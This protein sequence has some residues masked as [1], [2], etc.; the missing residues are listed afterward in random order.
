MAR[1]ISIDIAAD[2]GKAVKGTKDLSKAL[3]DVG[4]SLDDLTKDAA[5]AGD[6]VGDSLTDG[7]KDAE[8]SLDR[9]E[10]TFK[11]TFDAARKESK[12][13]GDDVGDNVKRGTDRASEAA[14]GFKDEARQNFAE[15]ASS[16]D[17]SMDSIAEMAQSTLG[18]LATAIPGAGIALAGLGAAAGAFYTMWSQNAEK[19]KETISDMY[20]DLLASGNKYLSAEFINQKISE[21]V[22]NDELV[23]RLTAA[24]RTIGVDV[25]TAIRAYSGDTE[26]MTQVTQ[27]ATE[28]QRQMG[29]AAG[30]TLV[31]VNLLTG[32]VDRQSDSLTSANARAQLARDA[33]LTSGEAAAEWAQAQAD[34]TTIIGDANTAINDNAKTWAGN[35]EQIRTQNLAVLNDLGLKLGEV[36]QAAVNAN[37]TGAELSRTQ[38]EQFDAFMTAAT[39]AGLAEDAALELAEQYGL[40]PPRVTSVFETP[41]LDG[42]LQK[43]R[44]YARMIGDIPAVKTVTFEGRVLGNAMVIGINPATGAPIYGAARAYGGP[45]IQG[46]TYTVGERQPEQFRAP[47]SGRIMPTPP[48]GAAPV[49]V[50]I[51]VTGSGAP[52]V[53]AQ[54]TAQ[55][56]TDALRRHRIV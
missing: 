40:I 36:N 55:R 33:M 8:K 24:A 45:V 22:A 35:E 38:R 56:L 10:R 20:D 4:D 15:T 54:R 16:F 1:G 34:L 48:A 9:L 29:E 13:A 43:A 41:G 5:K 52:D 19:V 14:E 46:E 3:D 50:T 11:E 37:V 27:A 51:N 31:D 23:A 47:S 6:K 21:T 44:D 49:S 53:V 28:W 7:A 25:T 18:G 2:V 42:A 26:A 30:S 12:K 17:G 32:A 39:G